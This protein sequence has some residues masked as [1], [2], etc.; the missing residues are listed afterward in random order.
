LPW[1]VE[2]AMKER[3]NP[4]RVWRACS[5]DERSTPAVKLVFDLLVPHLGYTDRSIVNDGR[6]GIARKPLD[7]AQHR[8]AAQGPFR[9][10]AKAFLRQ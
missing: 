10:I 1:T 9:R 5:P 6:W 3:P 4:P 8:A 2:A 7:A